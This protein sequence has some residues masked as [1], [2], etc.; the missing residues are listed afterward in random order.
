MLF[1]NHSQALDILVFRAIPGRGRTWILHGFS[2]QLGR[3]IFSA[4][5]RRGTSFSPFCRIHTTIIPHPND[6]AVGR[7]VDILDT[8]SELRSHPQAAKGALYLRAIVETCLPMQAP[9]PEV[10][11]LLCSLMELLPSFDDWKAAPLLL[12]LTFFEQEG[13]APQS[14]AV[15]PRLSEDSK[16][17]AQQLLQAN[18]ASWRRVAIPE[19]LFTAA[20]ET[21]GIQARSAAHHAP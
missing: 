2:D 15:L 4:V 19:D 10:W 20:M 9:S 17:I 5:P 14:L 6:F 1:V 13:I 12:A 8:F 11:H 21:I 3:V 16:A 18:E 7:D